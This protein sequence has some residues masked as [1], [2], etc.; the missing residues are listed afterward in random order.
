M[1]PIRSSI[2][3]RA[4]RTS[5][6]FAPVRAASYAA[7]AAVPR[8]ALSA[9]VRC[10]AVSVAPSAS[11][12][13]APT[14]SPWLSCRCTSDSTISRRPSPG[15]RETPA[16]MRWPGL[17]R[18]S[19]MANRS[20][21]SRA[22]IANSFAISSADL[23]ERCNAV[24][25][26][27]LARTS[28]GAD[29]MDAM[30]PPIT[31][32]TP[33][34]TPFMSGGAI[35]PIAPPITAPR[36][37]PASRPASPSPSPAPYSPPSV[38]PIPRPLTTC[39]PSPV[40]FASV[41]RPTAG[42]AAP[43]MRASISE[44]SAPPA[45]LPPICVQGLFAPSASIMARACSLRRLPMSVP[46]SSDPS[47]PIASSPKPKPRPCIS[48]VPSARGCDGA[49]LPCINSRDVICPVSGFANMPSGACP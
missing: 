14:R 9:A 45:T 4:L 17:P 38:A 42:A 1:P 6:G 36:R 19:A 7:S 44:D 18:A 20:C 29:R 47:A 37:A 43:A 27:L 28:L 46:P 31:L 40:F 32:S 35:P 39:A 24:I 8:A 2:T 12:R 11:D 23:P 33:A 34:R 48:P 41:P 15:V 16:S 3:E 10:A 21:P 13:K 49:T 26:P 22:A 30:G 25:T 5:T